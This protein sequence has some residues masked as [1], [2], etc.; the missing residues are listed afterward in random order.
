[1]NES[2]AVDE[3]GVGLQDRRG[4]LARRVATVVCVLSVLCTL[5]AVVIHAYVAGRADVAPLYAGN[6]VVA[7]AWPLAGLLLLRTRPG[8][9]AGWVMLGT[10]FLGFYV[11]LGE[12]ALWNARAADAPLPLAGVADWVSMFGFGVYFF[13]LPLLPMV[14]PDGRLPS[15]RWRWLLRAVLVAASAAT[16]ARMV[17]PGRS[18]TDPSIL[19]PIG[20]AELASLNWVVLA[21]S[22]FCIVVATPA[23]VVGV[24]LRAR[25]SVGVERA[26]LQW[27]L[28]AAVVLSV[29]IV[30]SQLA[31]P[32]PAADAIFA[33]GLAAPPVG[34]AVAVLRHRLV[35]VGLVLNRTL[36]LLVVVAAV[37]AG[38]AWV[39]LRLDPG[40]TGTRAG[41]LL[42]AAL[43]LTAVGLRA[44][45]QQWID[46]RWFPQRQDAELLGRRVGRALSTTAE[47]RQALEEL[48]RE[49]R[50]MLRLPFVGLTGAVELSV[51]ERVGRA[52]SIDLVALGRRLGA[53]EVVPRR[54][55]EGFTRQERRLLEDVA[56]RAAMIV[57][58]AMLVEDVAASRASIVRAREEERRRLRNDL[59]DGVGPAL[60]GLALQADALA[61]ELSDSPHRASAEGIRDRLRESV[62]LVRTVSH[63]LRPPVLDQLGLSESLRQ[64]VQ[65]LAP[66]EGVASVDELGDIPAAV[67][68]AAYAIAAEAVA[69]AVRHSAASRI[70]IDAERRAGELVV[71]VGDNGRGV[72]VRPRGGVGLASMRRRA[73]EV[74]GLCVHREAAGGGTAVEVVIPLE[75]AA[76]VTPERTR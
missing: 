43:V 49:V 36:V 50:T 41:V 42:V 47:P 65:G 12:Y 35:D 28:F 27:F 11:L 48:V 46:Q 20:V 30:A 2:A 37:A 18:D 64:L 29:A 73:L 67:E 61:G 70:R 31:G 16:L 69:N 51:G 66:I 53:L 19:N 38:G 54:E 15:P 6:V 14:F 62:A 32:G 7:T 34:V 74:D 45:L 40:L 63:G 9:R 39:L 23:A 13:V 17:V 55:T 72:P 5:G 76:D 4:R 58:A 75:A 1:M 33:L 68:V 44:L 60:A 10:S 52:M 24:V 59:H 71:R 25:R 8:N 57:Y 26:Q 21:G 3:A 22:Y 56:G